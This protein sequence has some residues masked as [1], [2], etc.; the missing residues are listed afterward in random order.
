MKKDTTFYLK[1]LATLVTI[2]GAICTSINLYPLGPAL[3]NVGAF[4]WL[5]VAIKWREWSLITINATLLL[6]Y[7]VG[8]VAK[9]A[10]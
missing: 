9:L 7:T 10:T 2:V 1:W 4:L 8:L 3:L 5:I 6:I